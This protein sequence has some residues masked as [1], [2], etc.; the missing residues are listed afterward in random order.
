MINNREIFE[1]V[2]VP[3]LASEV[4]KITLFLPVADKSAVASLSSV[5]VKCCVN[6]TYFSCNCFKNDQ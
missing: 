2:D 5:L 1:N 4:A 6:H 3:A